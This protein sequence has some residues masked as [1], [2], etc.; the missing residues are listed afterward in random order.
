MTVDDAPGWSKMVRGEIFTSPSLAR[1]AGANVA[2]PVPW[3]VTVNLNCFVL[4][5]T[6]AGI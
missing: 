5:A 3:F 1:T 6:I 2:L 4:P